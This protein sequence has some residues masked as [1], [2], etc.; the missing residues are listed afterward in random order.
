MTD[1][2]RSITEAFRQLRRF[3][4]DSA[5]LLATAESLFENDK[6][7]A[8]G[9]NW[10]T[11]MKDSACW[12]LG[13]SKSLKHPKRWIPLNFFRFFRHPTHKNLLVYVS[14]QVDTINES[15]LHHALI[16][17][18]GLVYPQDTHAPTIDS[19]RYWFSMLH[20]RRLDRVDD[21]TVVHASCPFTGWWKQPE[22]VEQIITL[23]RPL[24][25]VC[26]TEQ[27]KN[28]VI[29]PLVQALQKAIDVSS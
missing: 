1:S 24:D 7:I 20:I 16:T 12:G 13:A 11:A 9:N 17:A 10:Q 25:E 28:Q 6:D 3:C 26:N 8:L 23:A 22:Q 21:G 15:R 4:E 18:G 29:M 14:C 2:S 5:N 19:K 27:L